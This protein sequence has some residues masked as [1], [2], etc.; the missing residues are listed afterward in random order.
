[1]GI[2]ETM[3]NRLTGG[4]YREALDTVA[5][6]RTRQHA[7][8]EQ[9]LREAVDWLYTRAKEDATWT[10][11]SA[12]AATKSTVDRRTKVEWARNC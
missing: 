9:T 4:A 1:M 5:D 7:L 3:A 12:E 10:K 11:L 6:L 2:R 8:A